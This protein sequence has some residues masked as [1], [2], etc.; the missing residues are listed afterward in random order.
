MR[1]R[2]AA[3][4]LLSMLLINLVGC[5]PGSQLE[6]SD[7]MTE[8]GR[9]SKLIYVPS[10]HGS[11]VAVGFNTGKDGGMTFTPIDIDIPARYGVVFE[12]EHGSFAIEGEKWESLWRSLKEGD[13]VEIQYREIYEVDLTKA[14]DHPGYR[15]FRKLD[16]L[17]ATKRLPE[18]T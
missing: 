15:R 2:F 7:V 1:F 12:C 14:K 8:N 18:A 16:F 6:H 4:S 3:L 5:G 10:G 9:V 11:D 17:G 13:R